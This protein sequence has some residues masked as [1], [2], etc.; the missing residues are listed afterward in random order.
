MRKDWIRTDEERE[1]RKLRNIQKQQRK[2]NKTTTNE[3]PII[4]LPIVM[5][6]KKR[7]QQSTAKPVTQE[8]V[9]RKVEPVK[10]KRYLFNY[11]SIISS[12]F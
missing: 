12:L 4:N 10:T 9:V 3:Q 11:Y 8:L 6:K 7:I 2:M 1:L 5:R